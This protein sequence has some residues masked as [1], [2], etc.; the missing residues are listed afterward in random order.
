VNEDLKKAYEAITGKRAI[1]DRL[2]RYYDGDQPLVYASQ[3]LRE[4]FAGVDARFTENWCSVVVDTLKERMELAGLTVPDAYQD[5]FDDIWDANELGLESDDAHEAALVAGEAFIIAWPD[6]ET[7]APT[8][9]YNDPRMCHVFYSTD[10]PREIRYAAK[11]WKDDDGYA[12][13]TLYYP[14]RLE[15]YITKQKAENVSN[16]AAFRPMEPPTAENPYGMPVFHFTYS[17]RGGKSALT[18]IIPPQNGIN[19]LLTDMMVAAEYGAFRQRYIISNANLDENTLKNIPGA[20]WGIPAGDG[21]GQAS[22][23]GEFSATDLKNYLDA[24]SH[25]AGDVGRIT[26]IPKHYFYNQGGDPSGEALIAMEAPLTKRTE[27]LTERFD[28]VW[29]RLGAF[30][31]RIAG[32]TVVESDIEPQWLPVETVQPYTQAQTR[33][34]AKQAGMPLVTILRREGWSDAELEQMKEERE[35]SDAELGDNLL[36][37][38]DKGQ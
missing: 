35:A 28:P 13:L 8:A 37:A 22:S 38:F 23:A 4:I 15:Y 10:N 24:I 16:A 19:K 9:Y 5:Q 6:E 29:R 34:L 1:Y 33:L 27:K 12:R 18:D 3:R 36:N 20:V 25:L 7:G 32:V 2:F 30:V 26:R 11:M 21:M 17:R 31:L 14:D